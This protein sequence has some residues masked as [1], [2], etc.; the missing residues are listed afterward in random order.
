ME[1]RVVKGTDNEI[2]RLHVADITKLPVGPYMN[3][4]PVN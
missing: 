4:Y 3:I 1:E 2:L